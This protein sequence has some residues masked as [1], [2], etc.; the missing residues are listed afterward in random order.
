MFSLHH[1]DL[2]IKADLLDVSQGLYPFLEL[3]WKM[4]FLNMAFG[5]FYTRYFVPN[6]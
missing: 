2:K 3:I 1:S 4:S 6:S 5:Q